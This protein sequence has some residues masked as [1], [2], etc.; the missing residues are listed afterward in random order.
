[1]VDITFDPG[2]LYIEIRR[3]DK[4]EKKRGRKE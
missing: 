2:K 1:M 3:K 4:K